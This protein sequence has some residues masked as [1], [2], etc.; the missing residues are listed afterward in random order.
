MNKSHRPRQ[1]LLPGAVAF[2]IGIGLR[3]FV[4]QMVCWAT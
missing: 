3:L 1:L 2:V 4:S